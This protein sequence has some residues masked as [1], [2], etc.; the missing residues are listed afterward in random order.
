MSQ[1]E[2][3]Q[4]QLITTYGPGA[5]VDLPDHS[6]VIGGLNLWNYGKDQTAELIDETRLNSKVGKKLKNTHLVLQKPPIN[7]TGPGG[8]KK[9]GTI[10]SPQFPNW[11]VAQLEETI[12]FNNRRYRTRPLVKSNQLDER[13]RYIDINRKKHRVVPVRFVQSCPNGHL[14]DVN[15]REFVHKNNTKCKGGTL[16]LDE[17]GAGN[18]F[19][20][21]YVRCPKCNTRRPLSEAKQLS[22]GEK[23]IPALGYCSGQ[24][25]WLGAH[26]RERCVSDSNKGGAYPNRLLV[27]S[28]SNAYFPE[29]ISAISIPKPIDKVRE[30]LI[31]NLKLFETIDTS[32]KLKVF[33]TM[34]PPYIKD[35][36][37]NAD[38]VDIFEALELIKGGNEKLLETEPLKFEELKALIG[39]IGSIKDNFGKNSFE[40]ED[41]DLSSKPKWFKNRIN[42]VLKVHKLREVVALLSFTRLEPVVNQINGDPLD[43]GV[44]RASID[45]KEITWLP[46]VEN[47]GEGI[48]IGFDSSK[49]NDWLNNESVVEYLSTHRDAFKTWNEEHGLSEDQFR[50]PGGAYLMLHS[51]SHLLI[52][53]AAL[54]CGYS[55]S[56]IKERIYSFPELGYGILLYTGGS[57]SEGTL[58][59]LVGLSDKIEILLE[60]A[61]DRGKLC[62]N[63]PFC[64]QH[65]PNNTFEKR[66][67]HGAACHSCL[68]IAETS[69]ERKNEFLDRSLLVPT[70]EEK[71]AAFFD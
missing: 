27:R 37:S 49:I 44:R 40:A 53:Q 17:A 67:S 20:E 5:M 6:V 24:R 1:G 41:L 50:W 10:K 58:G 65:K 71:D 52:S 66:Y 12:V 9:G 36:L 46:A 39:P 38:P 62:S 59:G 30:I 11:F 7:E 26:G 55:A 45:N 54:D 23:G 48:F 15:W 51:L 56:S 29:I 31:K 42:R 22:I 14:S 60:K 34:L 61:L 19:A 4:S 21:I 13:N 25:P 47:L 2:V 33:L 3:R 35:P 32:E 16:W 28:A 63:D 43:L 69:C 70:L 8:I 68:L 18:D 64:S 57:G